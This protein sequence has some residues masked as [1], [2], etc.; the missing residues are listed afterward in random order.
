[1]REDK[2]SQSHENE[3]LIYFQQEDTNW[4][5]VLEKNQEDI[6]KAAKGKHEDQEEFN[7]QRI[8]YSSCVENE[9]QSF[10]KKLWRRNLS[11]LH[12]FEE[13][14]DYGDNE[15]RMATIKNLNPKRPT[16]CSN[17]SINWTLKLKK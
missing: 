1:M 14:C 6:Q 9:S 12:L 8:C 10:I 16:T 11:V 3:I 2:A 15:M 4:E 17:K 7:E 5:I 13:M